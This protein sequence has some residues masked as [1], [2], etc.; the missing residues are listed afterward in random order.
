M[1]YVGKV[2]AKYRKKKGISQ[3]FLSDKLGFSSAQ[4]I[5]NIERGVAPCPPKH[6]GNISRVIGLPTRELVEADAK[7]R[8]AYVVNQY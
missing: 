8:K 2:I 4:F 3:K 6:F 1:S 5:S 7:D